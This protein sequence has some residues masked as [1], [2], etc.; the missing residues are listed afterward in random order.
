MATRLVD[1]ELWDKDWFMDLSPKL[2]CLVQY[3]WAKCDNAGVLKPNWKLISLQIGEEVT[4]Q[5]L[6]QVDDGKQFESFA[7]KIWAVEFIKFQQKGKLTYRKPPHR[8]IIRL[9]LDHGIWSRFSE[10][11]PSMT[12]DVPEDVVEDEEIL[13]AL[14]KANESLSKPFETLSEKNE[15]LSETS[16]SNKVIVIVKDKVKGGMGDGYP[17]AE[18]KEFTQ[19]NTTWRENVFAEASRRLKRKLTDAEFGHMVEAFIAAE[20]AGDR[21]YWKS[22]QE[23]KKHCHNSIMLRVES[24]LKPPGS[25]SAV[26]PIAGPAG[27]KHTDWRKSM[28]R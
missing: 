27:P 20:V 12:K 25:N 22:E 9:L 21:Q 17:L 24:L 23:A 11:F 14:P 6:L 8:Q 16:E 28:Q 1:T 4:E 15:R 2:K 13:E 5:D 10:R 26:I 19:R 3:F 7:G 18:F